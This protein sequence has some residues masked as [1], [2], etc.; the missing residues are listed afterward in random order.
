VWLTQIATRN[1]TF[2]LAASIL[3]SSPLHIEAN[4]G[5]QASVIGARKA[6]LEPTIVWILAKLGAS[7]ALIANE[8]A[9]FAGHLTIC[10]IFRQLQ[11]A[12]QLKKLQ[13]HCAAIVIGFAGEGEF[14]SESET[15]PEVID[16][17]A[18]EMPLHL[19]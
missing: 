3:F 10:Q 11:V 18:N 7:G 8:S 16:R 15:A 13:L 5:E 9:R 19:H 2:I 12:I 1:A 17:R 4:A 14:E 6:K